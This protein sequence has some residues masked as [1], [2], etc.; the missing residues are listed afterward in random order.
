MNAIHPKLLTQAAAIFGFCAVAFGAFGAHALKGSL[1]PALLEVFKTAVFYQFIHTITLLVVAVL[2]SRRPSHVLLKAAG[3][4]FMVGIVL[5][6]GSLYTLVFSGL[7][8]VGLITPVGGL[9]F[10]LAWL[11]LFLSAA[12]LFNKEQ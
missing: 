11:L 7:T 10:L 12:E 2:L 9:S 4:S 6:C 5:F 8:L 1:S 3:L